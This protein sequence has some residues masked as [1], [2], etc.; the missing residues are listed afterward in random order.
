VHGDGPTVTRRNLKGIQIPRGRWC[1]SERAALTLDAENDRAAVLGSEEINGPCIRASVS[2]YGTRTGSPARTP[3]YNRICPVSDSATG[4]RRRATPVRTRHGEAG[5]HAQR[6]VPTGMPT[7]TQ[8]KS[9]VAVREVCVGCYDPHARTVTKSSALLSR[10][11]S[12][13]RP[14]VGYRTY[15]QTWSY[16]SCL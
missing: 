2:D 1:P 6:V 16:D 14:S 15:H 8:R 11:I 4:T 5:G 12:F 13:T 7:A 10:T 9:C 3:L